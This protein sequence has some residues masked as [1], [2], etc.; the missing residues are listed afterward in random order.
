MQRA[1]RYRF[2]PT[3][4]QESLLRRT[5]GCCRLAYNKALAARTEGWFQRGERISY[6]Q[7]DRMLTGWKKEESLHFLNEVSSV[8]LQQAL[9]HLQ[10]AFGNFWEKRTGYPTFKKKRGGGSATYTRSAFRFRDGQVFLAKCSEALPIRWSRQLPAGVEPSSVVVSLHSSGRWH[11]SLK[12]DD[13]TIQPL[14]PVER[15]IGLDA[16][17][18]ALVTDSDGN[19]IANPRT[20]NRF[21]KRMRRAQKALSRKVKGSNNRRKAKVRVARI[22]ARITDIRQNHL[23]QLSTRLIRENQTIVV[24]DLNI[25]GMVKNHSLARAISDASWS[26]LIRQLSYK[27]EWYGR[28]LVK[29]D[30]FFPSSK[31]CSSCGHLLNKLPL[32]V[33]SWECPSCGAIHDRDHNAARN[34]LAAGLAVEVCGASVRPSHQKVGR[35][36]R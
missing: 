14:P 25:R 9:R 22:H 24:E 2:Y 26:E 27:A 32:Q 1:F 20:I 7:T 5:I 12:V 16:G 10:T 19:T 8:P 21:Q 13:P 4:E 3:A 15:S 34:I 36:E 6:A 23:H 31:T 18:S 28:K 33:R 30:R 11:I 29:V 17:I 35:Q